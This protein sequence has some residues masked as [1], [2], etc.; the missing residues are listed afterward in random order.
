MLKGAVVDYFKM[1]IIDLL[2]RMKK[3][4]ELF[5]DSR[6]PGQVLNQVNYTSIPAYVLTAWYLINRWENF[7]FASVKFMK[8]WVYINR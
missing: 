3:M 1:L 8:G 5:K 4:R 7:V 6:L 2:E